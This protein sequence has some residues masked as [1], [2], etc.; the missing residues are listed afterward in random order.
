M[1]TENPA[2]EP[3]LRQTSVSAPMGSTISTGAATDSGPASAPVSTCSGRMPRAA[4][5]IAS[6]R[7]RQPSSGRRNLSAT[8]TGCPLRSIV[9]LMKFMAGEPTNDATKRFTGSRQIFCGVS[10]CWISA[11]LQAELGTPCPAVRRCSTTFPL[12]RQERNPCTAM[13][14]QYRSSM[15][16][17]WPRLRVY[18]LE[19]QIQR[20]GRVWPV[21]ELR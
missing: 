20:C 16:Q 13:V 9:P 6:L 12:R 2:P 10:S 5:P 19:R 17:Q 8:N 18:V 15:R 4:G 7:K 21:K 1:R 14:R 3:R 11:G